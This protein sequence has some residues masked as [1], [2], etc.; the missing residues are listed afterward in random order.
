VK[1]G[2][3]GGGYA[4]I[5]SGIAEGERVVLAEAAAQGGNE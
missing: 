3:R 4:E 5:L 2:L 1:V